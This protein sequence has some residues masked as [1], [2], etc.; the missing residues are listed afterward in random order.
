MTD[1]HLPFPLRVPAILAACA[2]A[3]GCAPTYVAPAAN[4][5]LFARQG[6]VHI[7]GALGTS[8]KINMI[9]RPL[10]RI[11]ANPNAT[12]ELTITVVEMFTTMIKSVLKKARRKFVLGK[13]RARTKLSGRI[14]FGIQT[15]R[16]GLRKT[17]FSLE[18]A[19][20]IMLRN[21]KTITQMKMNNTNIRNARPTLKDFL[22]CSILL[23]S[24][25]EDPE[26]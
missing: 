7:G 2:T 14:G 13:V 24:P 10:K 16:P 8:M 11:R 5:P 26:W 1:T 19:V 23:L 18:N 3:L 12:Q 21:G 22:I 17:S 4:A 20:E 6:Q 15:M 25:I 9:R